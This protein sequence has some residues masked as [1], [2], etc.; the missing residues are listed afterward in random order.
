MKNV[1]E[2][3]LIDFGVSDIKLLTDGANFL[4]EMIEA[5]DIAG[6]TVLSD[7]YHQFGSRD[8]GYTFVIALAESHVSC[9]T[10]PEYNL[11]TMDIFTCG[12]VPPANIWYEFQAMFDIDAFRVYKVHTQKRGSFE[13]AEISNPIL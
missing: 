8:M 6:A 12:D 4:P 7:H 2:H 9:H 5:C 13:Y 11:G 1:G 3:L 10:W